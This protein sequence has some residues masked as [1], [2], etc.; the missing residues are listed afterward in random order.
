MQSLTIVLIAIIAYLVTR[1]CEVCGKRES[2][3]QEAPKP[4]DDKFNPQP[5]AAHQNRSLG[6][7]IAIIFGIGIGLISGLLFLLFV[8][9]MVIDNLKL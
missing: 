9:P 7:K 1:K 3:F 2:F 4:V 6:E 8:V 5:S